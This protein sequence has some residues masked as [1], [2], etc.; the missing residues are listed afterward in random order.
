MSILAF[1]GICAFIKPLMHPNSDSL[2]EPKDNDS[3]SQI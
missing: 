1:G 2:S 3:T